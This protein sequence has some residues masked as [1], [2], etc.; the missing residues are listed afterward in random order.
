MYGLKPKHVIQHLSHSNLPHTKDTWAVKNL[1]VIY[2]VKY[3][4][5]CSSINL[6][7]SEQNLQI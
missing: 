4:I 7:Y 5:S 6:K 1:F 3:Y 2:L